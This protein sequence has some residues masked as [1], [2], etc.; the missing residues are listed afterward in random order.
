MQRGEDQRSTSV[1]R[2]TRAHKPT[3]YVGPAGSRDEGAERTRD[4]VS[5]IIIIAVVGK[6]GSNYY[7][8]GGKDD[9]SGGCEGSGKK[10]VKPLSMEMMTSYAHAARRGQRR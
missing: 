7:R 1:R 10:T 8:R 3:S 4:L 6:G 2:E 9:D 5:L